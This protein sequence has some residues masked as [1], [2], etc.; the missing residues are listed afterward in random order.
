MK[1]GLSLFFLAIISVLLMVGVQAATV[2]KAAPVKAPAVKAA[3]VVAPKYTDKTSLAIIKAATDFVKNYLVSDGV[4]PQITITNKVNSLYLLKIKLAEGQ[5][6]T[7]AITADGKYFFPQ[8][9][10]IAQYKKDQAAAKQTPAASAPTV[11]LPQSDKPTVD[12]FVMS[13]CPYGTQIEKGILPVVKALGDSINF[14]IKFVDYSMHGD[15]EITE[16]LRQYCI[17]SQQPS[18]FF[19]YLQ[20]FLGAADA[21][22]CLT[23]T[24][25]DQTKLASCVAATDQ[26]YSLTVDA[27]NPAKQIGSYPPFNIYKADNDKFNVQGSPT[28][29]INGQEA[30]GNRDSASLAKTI[31]A[32]FTAGHEPAA[33]AQSFSTATPAPGF[34]TGTVTNSTSSSCN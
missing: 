28:L 7:S 20:C 33:C 21:T 22:S 32:A 34:G 23:S 29:I 15:K 6:V 10:D 17:E 30:G 13:Y 8:L 14:Q 26:Q 11:N 9:M 18:K 16:N 19:D 12:L 5:E 27:A 2:P 4:N 25:I 24:N 3:K 1:K 31:C